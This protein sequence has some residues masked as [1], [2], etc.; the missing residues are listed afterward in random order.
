MYGY[1]S[2]MCKRMENVFMY[3][4]ILWRTNDVQSSRIIS[5]LEEFY[6]A[7]IPTLK[8]MEIRIP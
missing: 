2:E 8:Y 1:K 5:D 7:R 3:L 6:V 4:H